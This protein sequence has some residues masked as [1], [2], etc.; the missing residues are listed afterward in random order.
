M[1]YAVKVRS[2]VA[3]WAALSRA[4]ARAGLQVVIVE[5]VGWISKVRVGWVNITVE[6]V[7][8]S[9]PVLRGLH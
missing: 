5:R 3:G 2:S 6:G 8:W 1:S 9:A 7:G 4:V